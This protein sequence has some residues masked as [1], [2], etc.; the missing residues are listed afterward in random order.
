MLKLG[1]W[2]QTICFDQERGYASTYTKET[3]TKN[4]KTDKKK[5]SLR[6]SNIRL[7]CGRVIWVSY[8]VSNSTG[9]DARVS[10]C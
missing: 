2:F 9:G 5:D 1:E 8:P 7:N 4:M 10:E 6:R 3:Y